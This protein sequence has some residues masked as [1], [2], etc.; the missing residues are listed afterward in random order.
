[1]TMPKVG[2]AGMTHLAINSL[3]AMA[4]RGFTVIGFDPDAGK[5][6]AL[7][8]GDLPFSEP[9]IDDYLARNTDRILF[10]HDPKALAECDVVYVAPDV[11]TDDMGQSDLTP[12]HAMIDRV[13]SAMRS[14]AILVVL[15]QVPPGFTRALS[16]SKDTLFYQV[17]TLIFG[18]AIERAMYPERYI[19]GCA[20]PEVPLPEAFQKVLAAYDC[21]ILPMRYESAELCKISINMFL[22]STVTTTNTIAEL[23]EKIGADFSE[24]SPALRLDRRI[25]QYAYLAPGLGISGGN[26]ER[27]L[28]TFCSFADEYGTDADTVR[29]WIANSKYRKNWPARILEDVAPESDQSLK[30]GYLGL[31]YKENTSSIKNSPAVNALPALEAYTLQAY[32][33]MVDANMALPD[34][35]TRVASAMEAVEGVD[36]VMILTPWPEFKNLSVKAIAEAMT[37]TILIDPYR[38]FTAADCQASGLQH[39]T[40][41]R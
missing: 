28:F 29:A 21:P 32:D 6:N 33:P 2:F 3:A 36:I 14:D 13:D 26:L 4:E 40:L 30:I 23:C 17:E 11:P 1:M 34:N 5:A 39:V 35:T 27:D 12:I 24:I 10:T 8:S 38:I 37:G 41:G 19:V 9:E 25:G 22:V 15:S 18:R 31:A 7:T 16:R 20:A